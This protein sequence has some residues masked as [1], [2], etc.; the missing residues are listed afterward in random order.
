MK[1]YL[2]VLVALLAVLGTI[3]AP[4]VAAD[5]PRFE[6]YVPEPELRPGAQQSLTVQLVNDAADA[7]DRVDTATNVRVTAKSGST[8]IDVVSG[9]RLLG[10]MADGV[11]TTVDVRIEVPAT[12]K[13]G[14]YKLP[15][16]VTYEYE[17]DERD[18]TTVY[19]TVE[20]PER[21]IFVVDSVDSDLFLAETGVV[22]V[23]MENVGSLAGDETTIS[24]TSLN[25]AM[26]LGG[27][28][29]T[30]KFAGDWATGESK[31]ISFA[32]TA[33]QAAI[34]KEYAF[35]LQPTYQNQNDITTQ[36]PPTSI[37]VAPTDGNRFA[38]VEAQSDVVLGETGSLQMT[39]E[40]R[41]QTTLTDASVRLE[42]GTPAITF[43]GQTVSTQFIG[44]WEPGETRTVTADVTATKAAESREQSVQAT[45][46]F[47]HPEGARSQSGPYDVGIT[48]SP[49]QEFGYSDIGVDLRGSSAV[50]SAQV[51]NEGDQPVEDAVV[52][53]DSTSPSVQVLEP[54]APVG[55]LS[56]GASTQVS[57]D[58]RVS[59]DANP[60]PRQF[61]AQV[62]YDRGGAR[63]YQSDPVAIRADFPTD[64]DLFALEPV[65]NTF[66]IDTTNE[67]RV[68]IRN[69]GDETLSDIHARLA[70]LPPYESQSPSA[71]VAE[72][73][74]GE[75]AVLTFEVTTPE[76]AVPTS[77]AL[78][79]NVTAKTESDQ[80][81]TAGPYLVPIEIAASSATASDT[82]A[83]AVGAVVVVILLGVGWWWL[84]R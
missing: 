49:E 17:G 79:I 48:V 23:T 10:T 21:P 40:N 75:S 57:F 5:D 51:T 45:V 35:Q 19:A 41:G 13:G 54:T 22:T 74:P 47:K 81:I 3:P 67:F 84:N 16:E 72:L 37:G 70:A 27:S 7:D 25:P 80:T 71:Y 69:D 42:T 73:G 29:T 14:T 53:L 66:G 43:E 83:L 6:T 46:A 20:I 50:L 63:T 55:T 60:G 56:P 1:R 26:T 59:P 58:L 9:P 33:T 18:T 34:A 11:P 28:Q 64:E 2:A 77:D 39:L 15:L 68:R 44:Q 82:T 4:V 24:V 32:V 31:E 36:A 61:T 76:D 62:Q 65:N 12:A 38:V 8:P 52:T 30:T 78:G